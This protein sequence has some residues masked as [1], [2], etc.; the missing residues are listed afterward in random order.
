VREQ[1]P[2]TEFDEGS[3]AGLR[4]LCRLDRAALVRRAGRVGPF[5]Y[6]QLTAVSIYRVARLL[7][8]RGHRRLASATALVN[9][10]L[11]GA[12][13]SPLAVIGP[14]FQIV[15]TWGVIVGP[16]V[17]A[18]RNLTLFGG[19]LIGSLLAEGFPRLGDDVVVFAKASIL[20]PIE[21]GGDSRIGAH[22]LCLSDVPAGAVAKGIPART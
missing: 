17:V 12:E 15:H 4:A 7:R 5:V 1:L 10:F 2:L 16:T 13:L 14:G 11:T 19:V 8:V 21:I 20:G 18:G 3:L 6:P 9:Q 22:A